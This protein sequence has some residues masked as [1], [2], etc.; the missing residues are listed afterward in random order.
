MP[1]SGPGRDRKSA[2]GDGQVQ[3][4]GLA[5]DRYRPRTPYKKPP[6]GQLSDV[7]KDCNRAHSSVRSAVERA[8]AHF[9]RWRILDTGWRGR[10]AE[11]PDLLRTVTALEIYRVRG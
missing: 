5:V 9:T 1:M 2:R 10:L 8:I 4:R 3:A 7:L 6:G 11:F